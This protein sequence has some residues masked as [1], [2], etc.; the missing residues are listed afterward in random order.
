[1]QIEIAGDIPKSCGTCPMCLRISNQANELIVYNSS[2]VMCFAR[3]VYLTSGY[4]TGFHRNPFCPIILPP[5]QKDEEAVF[6]NGEEEVTIAEYR[7]N[8]SDTNRDCRSYD[9]S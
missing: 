7:I 1:M 6:W 3:K 9:L 4:L 2:I 5:E 8:I